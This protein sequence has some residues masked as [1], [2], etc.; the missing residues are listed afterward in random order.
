MATLLTSLAAPIAAHEYWLE[1]LRYQTGPDAQLTGH[2]RNGEHF[3]GSSQPYIP[4][5]FHRFEL[6][7][8]D[9]TA[10][11]SGRVGDIPAFSAPAIGEGLHIVSYVAA[12]SSVL[13]KTFDKFAA[14][15]THKALPDYRARHAAKGLD[16]APFREVYT[17]HVKALIG[18]GH[19]QGDDRAVG[20]ETEFVAL[21]NP[22][23]DALDA[24]FP[25]RL[26]YRGQPRAA[27]Q[28]EV[29]QRAP[30]G[31]VVI[32]TQT[33][34]QDGRALIP[35]RPGHAYLLDAVVLRDPTPDLAKQKNAVW[36]T[37]WAALTFAV[38]E[39]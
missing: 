5:L 13:Y 31:Q 26:L 30:D 15:A 33:T 11:V 7:L 14:F 21:A 34:D 38:P 1:P 16:G 22:Y 23:V 37:L 36:E 29:F 6:Q 3:K 28:I 39:K 25:V 35:V 18:V 9:K 8:N 10:P 17:R 2:L 32:T 4:A 24:G 27:A 19:S 12:P 20:L